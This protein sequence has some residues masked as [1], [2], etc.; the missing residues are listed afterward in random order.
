VPVPSYAARRAALILAF[1]GILTAALS[2][3]MLAGLVLVCAGVVMA[4]LSLGAGKLE[5]PTDQASQLGDAIPARGD[6]L[7]RPRL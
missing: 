2:A 4:I 5:L 6:E 3:D 1:G 7:T